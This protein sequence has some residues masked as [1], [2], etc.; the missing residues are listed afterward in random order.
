[1]YLIIFI[2]QW[3]LITT[4]S[5]AHRVLLIN[6]FPLPSALKCNSLYQ[7]DSLCGFFAAL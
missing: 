5:Y 1:M 3:F 4:N 7:S 6:M 2:L